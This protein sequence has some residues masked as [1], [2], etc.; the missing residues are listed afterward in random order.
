M[1]TVCWWMAFFVFVGVLQQ[2]RS[3]AAYTWLMLRRNL[4]RKTQVRPS[5]S[6]RTCR[7]VAARQGKWWC[8]SCFAPMR[9]INSRVKL[10]TALDADL[11]IE[12]FLILLICNTCSRES[13]CL[14]TVD[15][16]GCCGIF[17]DCLYSYF[18]QQLRIIMLIQR[19]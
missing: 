5:H 6:R 1:C 13:V 12:P 14:N 18:W 16:A 11:S 17:K 7:S 9:W 8:R 15:A 2:T 10:R 3:V 4:L 19:I